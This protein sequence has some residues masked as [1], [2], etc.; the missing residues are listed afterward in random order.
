MR[1]MRLILGFLALSIFMSYKTRMIKDKTHNNKIVPSIIA[2]EVE[3]ALSFYPSLQNTHIEFKIKPS[4][5]TS[6]MKAQ[7]VF[8]TVLGPKENRKYKILISDSFALENKELH[9]N[10]IPKKVL[11]GWLGHELGHIMD[12]KNRSALNL[13]GFGV[14]YYF[15]EN[16]IRKAERIADSFAI[17]HNMKDYILATKNF[18]LNHADLSDK[19]KARIKRLYVS[20]NEILKIVEEQQNR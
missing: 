20:P 5:T 14:R 17:S 7:P 10:Q 19:Y 12:Y 16:Y 9:L 15:S 8:S 6:F 11:I 1:L 18:I 3:A 2:N 13:L 4:L